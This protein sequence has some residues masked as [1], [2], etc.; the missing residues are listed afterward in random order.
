[1]DVMLLYL[2][3][4]I[5]Y[6]TEQRLYEISSAQHQLAR[7][8]QFFFRRVE[9]WGSSRDLSRRPDMSVIPR[10]SVIRTVQ[11]LDY[12]LVCLLVSLNGREGSI[13]VL[14]IY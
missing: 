11:G 13:I 7:G 3:L 5:G 9:G 14:I 4:I 1:M 2:F 8:V 12:Q 6:N 10:T